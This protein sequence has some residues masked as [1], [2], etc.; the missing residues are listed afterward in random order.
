MADKACRGI[1]GATVVDEGGVDGATVALIEAIVGSNGCDLGD[2]AAAIFTVTDDLEGANP[3]AAA[4]AHGWDMIPMLVVREHTDEH[5]LPRC[6]RVLVLWNT[7]RGQRE[8]KHAYLGRA[9]ALRP[10]IAGVTP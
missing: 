1:R 6:I 7:E 10:D 4:R 2:I 5:I 3:A 9:A 8:I